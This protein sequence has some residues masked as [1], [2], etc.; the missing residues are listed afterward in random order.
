[1]AAS[2]SAAAAGQALGAPGPVGSTRRLLATFDEALPLATAAEDGAAVFQLAPGTSLATVFT[3][4]V[5]GG[6]F[7]VSPVI[8]DL[9]ASTTTAVAG[10]PYA[11]TFELRMVR[12]AHDAVVRPSGER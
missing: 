8:L 12:A 11:L 6:P 3:L 10:A 1:M 5:G 4:P 9:A 2:R 7:A